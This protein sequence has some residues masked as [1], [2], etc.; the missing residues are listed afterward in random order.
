MRTS[1]IDTTVVSS[2]LPAL[3]TGIASLIIPGLGQVLSNQARRGLLMLASLGTMVGI[4][5]TRIFAIG[6]EYFVDGFGPSL[7]KTF[8][9]YTFFAIIMV[10]SL[11]FLYLWF[12]LDAYRLAKYKKKQGNLGFFVVLL[13]FFTLGY[14][15]SEID[16]VRMVQNFPDASRRMS[17]VMWPWEAAFEYDEER[18][19]AEAEILISEAGDLPPIPV[20]VEGEAYISVDPRFGTLGAVDDQY[21]QV[22]GSEITVT[23]RG[24]TPNTFTEIYW[25]DDAGTEFR[26]RTAGDYVSATTDDNGAFELTMTLPFDDTP[27]TRSGPLYNRVI[28]R[29]TFQVGG[30]RFSDELNLILELMLET[31]FMGM[32]ATIFGIIFSIPVSFLAARNIMGGSR[33]GLA[34]YYFTRTILNIIRSIE[35]LIW[36]V[37]AVVWVGIGTPFAGIIAL[38]IHSV[39]AL[40]KLYSEAIEGIDHGPIEAIQAT[41]ANQI[42]TIMFAVIPQ[43]ISPFVSFSIYRWDINVRMSTIIGMVGGGGIGFIVVQFIRLGL[44]QQAGIAVWFIAITVALLDYVSAEIR[45]RFM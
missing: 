31:I 28:A 41:G 2:P 17:R 15:L 9:R 33:L 22:P 1:K 34:V 39:A 21:N 20:E 23:G 16:L 30:A 29:Q 18:I 36:A 11:L 43:M 19:E 13:G 6:Q 26:P 45:N 3:L 37:I 8:E 4:L 5:I 10:L 12:A 7:A 42:Q 44:Y 14:Q 32:M 35:P 38:T 27:S 25:V 40:G 24:F